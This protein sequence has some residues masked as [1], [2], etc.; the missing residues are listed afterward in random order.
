VSDDIA[1]ASL[2]VKPSEVAAAN[3]PLAFY[4]RFANAIVP[5]IS[6][7]YVSGLPANV[8]TS[9]TLISSDGVHPDEL[10]TSVIARWMSETIAAQVLP[11]LGASARMTL[12]R[13]SLSST[14]PPRLRG[15]GWD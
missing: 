15:W 2:T 5:L 11:L 1:A 3:D 12:N 14:P 6:G 7:S 13:G 9:A 4:F 10:G 8:N